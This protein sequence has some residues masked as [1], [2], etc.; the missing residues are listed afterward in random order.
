MSRCTVRMNE[1]TEKIV[2]ELLD[3][4][5]GSKSEAINLL[6]DH[7]LKLEEKNYELQERIDEERKLRK[8]LLRNIE[9]KVDVL[10]EVENTRLHVENLPALRNSTQE[11][12]NLIAET[13]LYLEEKRRNEIFRHF[14][15]RVVD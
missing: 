10:Y 1:Q 3:K 7:Y 13:E 6:A 9:E 11:K 14:E 8:S 12:A 2:D 4:Y 15:K 5:G